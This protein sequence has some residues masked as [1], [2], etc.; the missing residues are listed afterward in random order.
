MWVKI[1]LGAVWPLVSPLYLALPATILFS[2]V[3]RLGIYSQKRLMNKSGWGTGQ[4]QG[5]CHHLETREAKEAAVSQVIA[6]P[7]PF[8][9]C[10]RDAQTL[11]G[12]GGFLPR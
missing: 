11:M 10:S 2:F 3:L 6:P 1:A 12:E 5:H 8:S 7:A 4:S 9:S